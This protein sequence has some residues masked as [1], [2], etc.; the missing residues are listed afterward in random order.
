MFTDVTWMGS[1]TDFISEIGDVI[2]TAPFSY[3]L[4]LALVGIVVGMVKGFIHR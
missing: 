1:I 3:F 2:M 4:I